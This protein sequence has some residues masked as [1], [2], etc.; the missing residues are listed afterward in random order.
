MKTVTSGVSSP[1]GNEVIETVNSST[2]IANATTTVY[3]NTGSAITSTLGA[4]SGY[5]TGHTLFFL[6]TTSDWN[7]WTITANGAEKFQPANSSTIKI[8]A[9][10]QWVRA[11]WDGTQWYISRG[12]CATEFTVTPTFTSNVW[13]SGGTPSSI[14]F[15]G[16]KHGRYLFLRGSFATATTQ[17][18]TAD[19]ILPNSWVADANYR[20]LS[21]VGPVYCSGSSSNNG[22]TLLATPSSGTLN[23][24][25]DADGASDL[26]AATATNFTSSGT[27]YIEAKIVISGWE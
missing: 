6:K 14:A 9:Q 25:V 1:T 10:G 4:G 22:F 7:A 23:F 24:G 26:T 16:S 20:T 17:S 3:G 8:H 12:D 15:Y 11:T 5:S 21:A 13:A 2:T 18:N 27:I 19:M